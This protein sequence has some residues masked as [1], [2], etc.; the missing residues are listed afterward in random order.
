MHDRCGLAGNT[1]PTDIE[2][3]TEGDCWFLMKRLHKL[4]SWPC[5]AFYEMVDGAM[6]ACT[7]GFVQR[8]DD[9]FLDVE[10]LWTFDA[11]W[12]AYETGDEKGII[13]FPVAHFRWAEPVWEDSVIA[14]K[15][16]AAELL[17]KYGWT[18]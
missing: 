10:G 3:M 11:M 2:R 5:Y 12:D 18:E 8:P 14:A 6:S 1:M 9:F 13:D 4:T 17:D 7:H 15:R 16:I